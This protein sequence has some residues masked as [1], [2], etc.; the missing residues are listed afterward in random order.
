MQNQ[1][2][3]ND[4][5]YEWHPRRVAFPRVGLLIDRNGVRTGVIWPGR[6]LVRKSRTF[7]KWIY[8][9]PSAVRQL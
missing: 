4:P 1:P 6:Y 2:A 7:S 5:D 3:L 9:Q 8:R